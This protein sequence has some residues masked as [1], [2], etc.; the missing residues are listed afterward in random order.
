MNARAKAF[1][2]EGRTESTA[3]SVAGYA[4]Q[5]QKKRRTICATL[6]TLVIQAL[7]TDAAA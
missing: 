7:L 6:Q 1:T 5:Q 4:S 2:A 3:L